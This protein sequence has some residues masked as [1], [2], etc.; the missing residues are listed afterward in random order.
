MLLKEVTPAARNPVPLREFGA[1]LRLAH[2][3]TDDGSE[4]GLLEL[5]LRNATAMIERRTAQ[6]LIS[7]MH[8][9]QVPCWDR[10][11]HLVM[12]IG[13]VSVIDSI[14]YVSPSSTVDLEQDDW[15]LQAGTN[16]Q[17]LTGKLG[18]PLW[19]LPHGSIAELRFMAG[20]GATWND[21]PDDLRQAVLLLAAHLY[22][23]RF[24]EIENASISGVP[25]G[26]LAIVEQH[27]AVRI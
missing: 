5:Y 19:P 7:R 25:A 17:R 27:R 26:V 14:Q 21:V 12:P 9:L 16:R 13:P 15:H 23:N 1:H 4:D 6:A 3:F 2:G 18:G 20:H 11:G 22:E 10:N 24:G 8:L